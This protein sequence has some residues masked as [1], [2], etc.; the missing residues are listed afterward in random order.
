M[1]LACQRIVLAFLAV[2]AALIRGPVAFAQAPAVAGMPSQSAAVNPSTYR[3]GAEDLL[4]VTVWR[5]DALKR[6]VLVRPDG[7]ISYPLIGEVQAAG[8]TV[9]E[10][11]E[12]ITKR[13][14]KFVPDAAVS[15]TV[16]K[17][18][19]QRIYVLGK[20][21][22][23]GEFPVGRNV[24]VLQA[25]SMAGGLTQ[26]ADQNGIRIMR[27]DGDRQSTLP[28]EYGRVIRGEKL[29]QNV[30]LRAGDVVVVP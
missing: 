16:L 26:F 12:E 13:L 10:L 3:V 7:G 21:T 9:N 19:S 20:V 6:D 27:R 24:D 25:L 17:T 30:L 22:K 18:G 15:V 14:E 1:L 11:R 8:K 5:E 28:F 29:E 23:P 2:V 4:E